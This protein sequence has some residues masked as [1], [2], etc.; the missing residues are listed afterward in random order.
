MWVRRLQQCSFEEVGKV[1]APPGAPGA[2]AAAEGLR[3]Q[4]VARRRRA[5]TITLLT[6]GIVLALAGL[7]GGPGWLYGG[8]AAATALAWWRRPDP[9]PGRWLRGAAGEV[10]TAHILARLPRRFVVLHDQRLPGGRGNV[11]HVVLGPT[12]VWVVDSKLRRSRLAVRHGQVFAGD[13]PIDV[14]PAARQASRLASTLGV[15]VR[16]VVA[17]HGRGLRRRGKRVNGVLVLPSERVC[18]R[19]RRGRR[20]LST[21]EMASVR[22]ALDG[23]LRPATDQALTGP[24]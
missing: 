5:T 11:D 17:V 21:R 19:L 8:A 13:R 6:S 22:A 1:L 23:V 14:A 7:A 24:C 3:A 16:A 20:R 10:A 12:G 18:R 2:S 4:R 9:D 15:P